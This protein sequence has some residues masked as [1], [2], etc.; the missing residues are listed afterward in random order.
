[1]RI[2]VTGSSKLAGAIIETFRADTARV[3]DSIDFNNYD[4]FINN[5]HVDFQQCVLLEKCFIYWK[6]D[7]S[8]LIINISSRA[9]FPNLSKGY[10]YGAQKAA[11]NHMT[12]NM[13]FNSDK[14]CRITTINLGMLE[15]SL[16]SLKYF[17]VI[18][19]LK[20]ITG[21]PN[22]IEIPSIC[23][24]HSHNYRDVQNLKSNRYA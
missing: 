18:E 1:M 4:I 20:F 21:L 13:V 24:Q 10:M 14:Q 23:V 3:E 9:G 17:E 16:P 22:H 6:K 5:A 2:L 19:I 12:D 15:D 8:K 11:L 7:P